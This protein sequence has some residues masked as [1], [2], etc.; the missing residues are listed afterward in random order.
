MHAHSLLPVK[1]S[2]FILLSHTVGTGQDPSSSK[3]VPLNNSVQGLSN[4]TQNFPLRTP[5]KSTKCRCVDL[6]EF[7]RLEVLVFPGE[8]VTCRFGGIWRI[9]QGRT[10]ERKRFR[11]WGM[12]QSNP[13]PAPRAPILVGINLPSVSSPE[14]SHVAHFIPLWLFVCLFL[15]CLVCQIRPKDAAYCFLK[16]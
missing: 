13:V 7:G 16:P 11:G 6:L 9:Q 10:D 1:Y 4:K 3:E 8:L 15:D 14:T 2:I 12:A 5:R